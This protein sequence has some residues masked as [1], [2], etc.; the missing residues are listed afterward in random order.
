VKVGERGV[1]DYV[2]GADNGMSDSNIS[3]G[4]GVFHE[5]YIPWARDQKLHTT[6][7]WKVHHPT[8]IEYTAA[9]HSTV[10]TT[11]GQDRPI[12]DVTNPDVQAYFEQRA[13]ADL[14][15]G[16][17]GI[18]WDTGLDGNGS[19]AGGHYDADPPGSAHYMQPHSLNAPNS[20][21]KHR[22][23]VLQP[24]ELTLDSSAAAVESLRLLRLSRDQRM[25]AGCLDPD[26]C[27]LALA[28]RAPP[29]G[30]FPLEVRASELSDAVTA[31]R[32]PVLA[33]LDGGSLP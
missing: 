16:F 3:G 33:P 21:W 2:W 4:T 30:C 9:N 17:Q 18:S 22:P 7:W 31:H 32:R 5:A 28:R 25:Q 13:K 10:A 24:A 14:A 12:L 15:G 11:F 23:L 8:W 29:L 19:G 27:G 20:E 6:A 1:L 26:A